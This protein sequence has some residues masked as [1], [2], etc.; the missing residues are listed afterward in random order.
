MKLITKNP[1]RLFTFGC[2][3]THY[4][5]S[6][7]PEIIAYDLEIPLYNYGQSGAGNQYIS[8]MVSQADSTYKFNEDD[9]VIISWTNVAREDRWVNGQWI[10]PG[11]IYTQ[12]IYEKKFVEK[13]SDPVGYLIR[14]LSLIKLTKSFLNYKKCQFHFFSMCDLAYQFNQ[15]SSLNIVPQNI[16]SKYERLLDL[17]QTEISCILPSFYKILWDNDIHKN[18]FDIEESQGFNYFKD[19]HPYPEEHFKYL[20]L[21]FDEHTF[22]ENTQNKIL[23]VQEKFREFIKQKSVEIGKYWAIY[24]LSKETNDRLVDLVR[25]KPSE[26]IEKV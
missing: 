24:E 7:W 5:W 21:T 22:S 1:K 23:D 15:N 9:L 20:K 14:D 10:T 19:G 8:N 4:F 11:N 17:Y 18:K 3:F 6:T 25:I 12:D 26:V 2:S 16:K 13:W